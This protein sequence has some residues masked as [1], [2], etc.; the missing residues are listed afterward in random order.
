MY[1]CASVISS[2]VGGS[3][4]TGGNRIWALFGGGIRGMISIR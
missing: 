3:S 2:S 4:G 1:A